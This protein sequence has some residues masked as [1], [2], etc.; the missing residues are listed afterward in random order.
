[1]D[2]LPKYN[3]SNVVTKQISRPE[4]KIKHKTVKNVKMVKPKW[5]TVDFMMVGAAVLTVIVM[6]FLVIFMAN[7]SATAN[8]QLSTTSAQLEKVRNKNNDL[9][10]EVSDLSSPD[11]LNKIAEKNGLKLNNQN[12]RNVK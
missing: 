6:A 11:R 5:D 10:Q 8:T 3:N 7:K 9:K 4:T 1:M 2:G 12:I